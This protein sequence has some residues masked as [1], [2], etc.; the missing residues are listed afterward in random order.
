[1]RRVS[2]C[3]QDRSSFCK[4]AIAFDVAQHRPANDVVE[5][6][7]R[8][9]LRFGTRACGKHVHR[10]NDA[11]PCEDRADGRGAFRGGAREKLARSD[12]EAGGP[13]RDA[14]EPLQV[15][16]VLNVRFGWSIVHLR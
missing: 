1:M 13:L 12:F 15:V 11:L 4:D 7:V 9:R 6:L 2:R 10:A 5:P 14:I 8:V 3:V 16:D